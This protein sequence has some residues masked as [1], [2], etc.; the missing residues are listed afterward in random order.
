MKTL[1]KSSVAAILVLALAF[2]LTLPAL[3]FAAPY[4][5]QRGSCLQSAT[6]SSALACVNFVER[7]VA[8]A[9]ENQQLNSGLNYIDQ[10]SNEIC[11][12]YETNREYARGY[13]CGNGRGAGA[14]YNNR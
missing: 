2:M 5:N 9:Y 10:N 4:Q 11:D 14:G 13:G 3:A 12:N 1:K 7:N 8:K 6:Q